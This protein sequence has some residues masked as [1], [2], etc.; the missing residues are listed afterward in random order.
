MKPDT[1]QEST[2]RESNLRQETIINQKQCR[3]T[4]VERLRNLFERRE[5]MWIPLNEIMKLGIAQHGTRIKE[6]KEDK[7]RPMNIVNRMETVN[8]ERYS[9]YKYVQSYKD[10]QGRMF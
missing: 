1:E 5:G 7:D 9:W 2:I 4:Q 3:P 10:G 8:G 6:L